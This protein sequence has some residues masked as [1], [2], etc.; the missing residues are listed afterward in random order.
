MEDTFFPI[1]KDGRLE[2]FKKIWGDW[3]VLS[4]DVKDPEKT[5][6]FLKVEWE[7]TVKSMIA[8]T[9][10]TY[11]CLGNDPEDI[12]RSTKG[13]PHS[14]RIEQSTF[15]NALTGNLD[16]S[17]NTVKIRSLGLKNRVMHCHT[18]IEKMLSTVFYKMQLDND[19]I[20]SRP[21][22]INDVYL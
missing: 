9:C 8:L 12:K 20:T 16:V 17:D 15:K 18:T 10:K 11:Q 21:L 1:I 3:F 19:G 22:Q 2:D 5:P 7:T 13:V 6:G 4:D 14:N